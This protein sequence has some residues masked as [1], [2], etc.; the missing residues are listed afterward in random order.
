MSQELNVESVTYGY[1]LRI[2]GVNRNRRE[3]MLTKQVYR[4]VEIV[5]EMMPWYIGLSFSRVNDWVTGNKYM[6]YGQ[7]SNACWHM[8]FDTRVIRDNNL[9]FDTNLSLGEDTKYLLTYMLLTESIGYLD[10]PCY[11]LTQ[12]KTGANWTSAK[13][14]IKRCNDKIKSTNIEIGKSYINGFCK[15]YTVEKQYVNNAI[16]GGKI[17]IEDDCTLAF[18]V[19]LCCVTHEIGP[20]KHR[21]GK[22]LA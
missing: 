4:G 12:R 17:I 3:C 19:T 16:G 8:M 22:P 18:G 21:A 20:M 9:L 5:N 7:E 6:K 11:Y 10:K 1:A 2:N 13:N 15:F 14:Y